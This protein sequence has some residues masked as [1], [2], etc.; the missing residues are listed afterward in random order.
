MLD[1][2]TICAKCADVCPAEAIPR[3]PRAE[4]DG[5][6]RWQIDQEQCFDFW[7]RAGTDCGRCIQV[8]PYSH[9]D[10]TLH[11]L[12]RAGVDR[13]AVFRRLALRLDDVMYE[14]RPPSR[15]VKDWPE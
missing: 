4:V 15:Q 10:N 3:G 5:A 6:Q 12:V 2:C 13:S 7:C 8:C 14:R 9:P 11:R 1:F